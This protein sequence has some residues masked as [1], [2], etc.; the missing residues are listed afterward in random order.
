MGY[1]VQT[2]T[3]THR[4]TDRQTVRQLPWQQN[5]VED[6]TWLD[7]R[8]QPCDSWRAQVHVDRT[9]WCQS[10]R[11]SLALGLDARLYMVSQKQQQR[12]GWLQTD[13]QTSIIIYSPANYVTLHSNASLQSEIPQT[14]RQTDRR[15]DG[16][17]DRQ[18]DGRTMCTD[19]QPLYN[20]PRTS[21]IK[22]CAITL[23]FFLLS[24][25]A[26]KQ[27]V[28][29]CRLFQ[30]MFLYTHRQTDTKPKI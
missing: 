29:I 12:H 23:L 4:Q 3:Q 25:E 5:V 22:L 2:H 11:T 30:T 18:M 17:T 19:T 1:L 26:S 13:K 10:Y 27:S 8:T 6:S 21:L 16:E 28:R 15:T 20:D 14:D 7:P 9:C 24:D